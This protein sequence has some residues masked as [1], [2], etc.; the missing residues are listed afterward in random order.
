[1]LSVISELKHPI[2]GRYLITPAIRLK[3]FESE[4]QSHNEETNEVI[5]Q[6]KIIIFEYHK[7]F[8]ICCLRMVVYK[9][10]FYLILKILLE[11]ICVG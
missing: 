8:A 6:L 1:M 7:K 3:I 5:N 11:I 9:L 4:E 2:S 10:L